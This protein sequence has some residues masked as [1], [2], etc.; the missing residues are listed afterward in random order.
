MKTQQE[1]NRQRQ[2]LAES[3]FIRS[4]HLLQSLQLQFQQVGKTLI[5]NL[6]EQLIQLQRKVKR[7]QTSIVK[8]LFENIFVI[9]PH[10][11][12]GKGTHLTINGL[13]IYKG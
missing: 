13:S 7:R 12:S 3:H 10:P 6:R 9:T 4:Q 1:Q 11:T 5:N 8:C 2:A